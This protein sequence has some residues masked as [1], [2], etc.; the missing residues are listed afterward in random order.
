MENKNQNGRYRVVITDT[1]TGKVEHDECYN[2]II[3]GLNGNKNGTSISMTHAS[4]ADICL[5][6]MLATKAIKHTKEVL[7]SKAAADFLERN[8]G[9]E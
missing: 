4:G 6:E 8:G 9:E 5:G 7:I 3:A 1:E 2:V